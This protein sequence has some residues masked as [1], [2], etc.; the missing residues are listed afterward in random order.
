MFNGI[1]ETKGVVK[2]IE[3]KDGCHELTIAPQ[4]LFDDLTLGDS[5]AVNGVCLTITH[6]TATEF[7]VTVVPETLRCSN[8]K[9]LKENHLVNLERSLKLG[10]RIGGH[11]V[12]GHVDGTGEILEIKS[13]ASKALLVKIAIP[14]NLAK[15]IIAKGFITIDGMSITVIHANMDWFTVTFIPYTQEITITQHYALNQLVNIEVDMLGKYIEK[16]A[17]V[18]THAA[19]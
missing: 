17:G 6:F 5:I 12:Q 7:K 16:L 2:K 11:F 9:N 18:H 3:L 19:H 8:L 15:Y 10:A 13:D 4:L 1:V 14:A